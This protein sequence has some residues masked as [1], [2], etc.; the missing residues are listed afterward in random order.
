[1]QG[2]T[3]AVPSGNK[4]PL[5]PALG[6]GRSGPLHPLLLLW[7]ESN[8]LKAEIMRTEMLNIRES[9]NKFI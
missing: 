8:F 1:M 6:I 7:S 3:H 4:Y 5:T 2:K 9:K